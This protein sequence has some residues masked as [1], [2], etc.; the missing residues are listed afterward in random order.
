MV[1]LVT[2][3]E[4]K[5]LR[6]NNLV[7]FVYAKKERLVKIEKVVLTSGNDFI[8][9]VAKTIT[10]FDYNADNGAGGYRS[11]SVDKISGLE[12]MG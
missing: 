6:V 11:F 3:R 2:M 10:G 7:G 5:I 8:G 1:K 12:Y 4:E 9:P